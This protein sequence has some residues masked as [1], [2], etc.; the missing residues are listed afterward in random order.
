MDINK[1]IHEW[2][3][4]S[5]A[6]DT[7]KYLNKYHKEAIIDDPSV[8]QVFKG[9]SGIRK[10]FETY[11][12]GYRTQTKLIK[13]EIQDDNQAHL[14]VEFTGDFP[15]GKLGGIFE[16]TFRED[17]IKAVKADLNH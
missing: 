17:K 10:Y 16:I 4:N 15:E 9:H 3:E 2:L 14:E 6:Y 11:F 1:F 8:G 12:I 7:D 13:L 5:N